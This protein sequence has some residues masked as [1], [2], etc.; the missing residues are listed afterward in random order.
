[1]R[2]VY[3]V[4]LHQDEDGRFVASTRD[5]PEAITDGRSASEALYEMRDA[6]G[7]ALA[8]Y[9]I[10]GRSLPSPSALEPQEHLVPVTPLVAAK[11]AL[12]EAMREERLSNVSLAER[13]GISEGAVRRLLNPDHASRL[14]GVVAALT[15]AGRDLIVEDI[16]VQGEGFKVQ[17]PRGAS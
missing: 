8:D 12:R 14:D 3:P 5:V 11:L 2:Y 10:T 16:K 15:A 7:A 13:L 4:K 17:G 9:V 6:L 1:M